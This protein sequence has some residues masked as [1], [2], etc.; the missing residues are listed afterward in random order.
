MAKSGVAIYLE[1][2]LK[3]I[4]MMDDSRWKEIIQKGHDQMKATL[5]SLPKEERFWQ[6]FEKKSLE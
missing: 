6:S 5:E 3:G 2:E 4:R 1:M